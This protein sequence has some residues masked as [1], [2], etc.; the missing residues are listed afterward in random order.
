M[1]R[2]AGQ[3]DEPVE[4]GHVGARVGRRAPGAGGLVAGR[5]GVGFA[6]GHGQDAGQIEIDRH[7]V[8][9]RI[10]ARGSPNVRCAE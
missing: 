3:P 5:A 1:E 4:Q 2:R 7:G 10:G 6:A 9:T 8:G